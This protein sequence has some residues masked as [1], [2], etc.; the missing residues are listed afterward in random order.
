MGSER[1]RPFRWDR[2]NTYPLWALRVVV[3]QNSRSGYQVLPIGRKGRWDRDVVD[4]VGFGT[5]G[6]AT[7]VSIHEGAGEQAIAYRFSS[8]VPHEA[9]P[10]FATTPHGNWVTWG[11]L[12]GCRQQTAQK[13]EWGVRFVWH[14]CKDRVPVIAD[15]VQHF[16]HEWSGSVDARWDRK[17]WPSDP[18]NFTDMAWQFFKSLRPASPHPPA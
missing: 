1:N 11:Y 6:T 18:P 10:Q 9:S 15:F 12:D 3:Q 17:Y 7:C 8:R 2:S 16:G 5:V 4:L 14:G 13:A